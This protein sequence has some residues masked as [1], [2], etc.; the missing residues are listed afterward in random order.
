LD[1]EYGKK[2]KK[3]EKSRGSGKKFNPRDKEPL[4]TITAFPL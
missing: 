3:G 1:A 2:E 4:G